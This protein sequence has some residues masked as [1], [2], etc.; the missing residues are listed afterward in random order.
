MKAYQ[1]KFAALHTVAYDRMDPAL[2]TDAQTIQT[3]IL[4][5]HNDWIKKKMLMDKN[6]K[7]TLQETFTYAQE[8]EISSANYEDAERAIEMTNAATSDNTTQSVTV[9]N[10][11]A[12][13]AEVS[14]SHGHQK[15]F[16]RNANTSKQPRERGPCYICRGMGHLAREKHLCP[17]QQDDGKTAPASTPTLHIAG[18]VGPAKTILDYHKWLIREDRVDSQRLDQA[19]ARVNERRTAEGKT[20]LAHPKAPAPQTARANAQDVSNVDQITS[21]EIMAIALEQVMEEG[22]NNTDLTSGSAAAN[23]VNNSD[24]VPCSHPSE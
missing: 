24:S 7:Y 15:N 22:L 20:P 10:V 11:D 17:A 4:S 6:V 5:L 21:D 12:E 19:H 1:H 23:T 2:Q 9:M 16:N 3:F 14:S 18:L 8:L 13:V